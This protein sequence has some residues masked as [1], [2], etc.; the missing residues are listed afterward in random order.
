MPSVGIVA[1]AYT[2]CE[3]TLAV[4]FL[5]AGVSFMGTFYPSL[6][7][8]PIDLSPNHAAFVGAVSGVAGSITGIIVPYLI[9]V[10]T[11]DVSA[12]KVVFFFISNAN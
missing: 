8:N 3:R 2:N 9:G 4:V 5:A 11:P 10:I 12:I 1:S 6:K 7:L